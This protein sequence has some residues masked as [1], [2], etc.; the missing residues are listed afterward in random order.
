MAKRHLR[1]AGKKLSKELKVFLK[2]ESGLMSRESILKVGIGT[3]SALGMFAGTLHAADVTG[4]QDPGEPALSAGTTHINADV[5]KWRV[6]NGS[7]DI[8]PSHVH[9]IIITPP[10][11]TTAPPWAAWNSWSSY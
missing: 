11:P 5:M 3:I 7:K 2:D 9:S 8:Y 4:V 1:K 6:I 10:P